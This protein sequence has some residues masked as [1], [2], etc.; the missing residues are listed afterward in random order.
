MAIYDKSIP[1]ES[2]I[3]NPRPPL[4]RLV[5]NP[6]LL[7]VPASERRRALLILHTLIRSAEAEGWTVSDP[8]GVRSRYRNSNPRDLVAIDAGHQPCMIRIRMKQIRLPHEK[9]EAE[10]RNGW[11]RNWDYAQTDIL[12]LE[13]RDDYDVTY[14]DDGVRQRVDEQLDRA[15]RR[16][17]TISDRTHERAMK[18]IEA[19][20]IAAEQRLERERLLE[21]IRHYDVWVESVDELIVAWREHQQRTEA[22]EFIGAENRD[23]GNEAVDQLLAWFAGRAAET[24]PVS[25]FRL[26]TAKEPDLG[27]E[28]RRGYSSHS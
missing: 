12:R 20:R 7:E 2:Q 18:R 22:L 27:H 5:D 6:S 28:E 10:Q 1:L 3:R 17:Q 21:T 23:I 11:G 26:P 8:E 13:V 15:L 24:N 4:Q 14:F 25:T 19:E 16:I 9:T